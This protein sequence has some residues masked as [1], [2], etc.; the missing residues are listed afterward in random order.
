[1]DKAAPFSA[2]APAAARHQNQWCPALKPRKTERLAATRRSPITC[3][4]WL[5]SCRAMKNK[6]PPPRKTPTTISAI[7]AVPA[8]ANM[9]LLRDLQPQ[10]LQ[11]RLAMLVQLRRG[12]PGPPGHGC[13]DFVVPRRDGDV[14]VLCRESG[15]R[16]DGGMT[17]T[18][19][20][21]YFAGRDIA[22]DRVLQQGD[23]RI[24][25]RDV[26]L[27]AAC[28]GLALIKRGDHADGGEKS[29]AEIAHRGADTCRR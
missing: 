20:A 15:E 24:E 28:G 22:R 8:K 21:R 6:A 1:M 4:A 11:D 10:L 27:L 14:A 23:L 29:G 12:G 5:S 26:D 25:H 16:R 2:V 18:E 13:K 7:S 9:H 17:R 19:P 3:P